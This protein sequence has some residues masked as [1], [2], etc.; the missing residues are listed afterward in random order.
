MGA[1]LGQTHATVIHALNNF[2]WDY[3]HNDAFKEAYNR[4]YHLYTKKGTV[5]TVETLT[6]ENR[7]L[8]EKIVELKGQIEELRG[9]VKQTRSNN[10]KPR[11]QQT[12]VY[13]ASETIN[14]F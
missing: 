3:Q 12:K 2:K 5:A 14:A 6:Y 7:V 10:I 1:T 11:N 8:E 9:E 4:V 13:A